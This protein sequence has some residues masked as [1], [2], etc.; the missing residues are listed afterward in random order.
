MHHFFFISEGS[1]I[2]IAIVYANTL[3][4]NRISLSEALHDK[5]NLHNGH[6]LIIGD[7]NSFLGAREKLGGRTPHPTAYSDFMNWTNVNSLIHLDTK[8]VYYTLTNKIDGA[9]FIAQKLDRVICNDQWLDIWNSINCNTLLR[10]FSDHFPLL[11]TLHKSPHIDIIP[12]FKF[13][14][15]LS[16]IDSCESL[17]SDHL[18]GV[19]SCTPMHILHYKLKSLT[20]KLQH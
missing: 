2:Y 14:K 8:G 6:W 11:V 19:V 17:I 9:I 5:F 10:C 4:N 1:T 16:D 3:Y 18:N 13:F 7:F 15:F 12:R 20:P